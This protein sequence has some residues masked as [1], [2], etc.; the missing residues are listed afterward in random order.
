VPLRAAG[1]PASVSV[2]FTAPSGEEI[3][4]HL[5]R[6][7]QVEDAIEQRRAGAGNGF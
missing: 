4:V 7:A 2:R 1:V 3:A 5:D 6:P